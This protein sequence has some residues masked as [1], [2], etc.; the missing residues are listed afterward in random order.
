MAGELT[1]IY[2]LEAVIFFIAVL[3]GWFAVYFLEEALKS[4]ERITKK[5]I[6]WRY[7]YLVLPL[8][9]VRPIALVSTVYFTGHALSGVEDF[10]STIWFLLGSIVLFFVLFDFKRH[11]RFGLVSKGTMAI[12]FC[13]YFIINFLLLSQLSGMVFNSMLVNIFSFAFLAAALWF[14]AS[15]TKG[16]SSICPM[17]TFLT[18]S[19]LLLLVSQVLRLYEFISPLSQAE[20][21][22]E[23]VELLR[24]FAI[25]V[26]FLVAAISTYVFKKTVIEFSLNIGVQHLSPLQTAQES[27]AKK[28]PKKAKK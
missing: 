24:V 17:P 7:I 11:A 6:Y 27:T 3:V 12:A 9:L 2:A 5:H 28:Q 19:G 21:T 1:S 4:V 18:V 23:A 22:V 10:Y 26:G 14:V 16:F 13:F 25:F 20:G 15:Y 8:I